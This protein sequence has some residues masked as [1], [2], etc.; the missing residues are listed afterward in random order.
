MITVSSST[1]EQYHHHLN[2]NNRNGPVVVPMDHHSPN[3]DDGLSIADSSSHSSESF[4]ENLSRD[5]ANYG[6]FDET[7][8]N[9]QERD[10][11]QAMMVHTSSLKKKQ[12]N[13]SIA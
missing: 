12:R 1:L 8:T 4:F 11:L 3:A 6:G 13:K 5:G 7:V 9:Q 10:I 2:N